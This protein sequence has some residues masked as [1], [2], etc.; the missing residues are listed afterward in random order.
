MVKVLRITT[1][2]EYWNCQAKECKVKKMD[3]PSINCWE[4]M[5]VDEYCPKYKKFGICS[6]CPW[7]KYKNKE[8][9]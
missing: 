3:N 9:D 6:K 2:W 1:C 4:E 5:N 7:Y 8:D